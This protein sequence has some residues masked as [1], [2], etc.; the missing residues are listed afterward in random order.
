[1]TGPQDGKVPEMSQRAAGHPD[2]NPPANRNLLT[3]QLDS[4]ETIALT[5]LGSLADAAQLLS[6]LRSA[7]AAAALA[8]M[9]STLAAEVVQQMDPSMAASVLA[10]VRPDD[11]VDILERI[12]PARR[13]SLMQRLN[14]DDAAEVRQLENYPPDSAGGI[15]TTEVAAVVQDLT[16][17]AAIDK[18]RQ[19]SR[20]LD[21][22]Y[23][24]YVINN[25]GQLVGVL[26]MRE[27]LLADPERRVAE[28][29]RT[30]V[31]CVEHG[32]DQEE[33][34]RLLQRYG[35]LAVPVVDDGR[36]LIGL[37]TFDD[38]VDVLDEEA[39]EDIQKIGGS[40]ALDAPYLRIGLPTML[41]KRGG[42]LSALFLGEMLTA[43]AMGYFEDQ[44]ARAVVLVLFIPL[45]ISSGGNAGSQAATLIVRA[46]AV[47]E[48]RLRDWGRVLWRELCT[49]A[50]LGAWL[51]AI[52]FLRIV[53]WQYAGWTDYGSHPL[54]LGLSVWISLIG[55]VLIGTLAGSLLPLS[56]QWLGF[57]PATSSAPFVA[58][59]V[60]VSGLV[61]Y[62][63]VAMFVLGGT[64]L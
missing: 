24:V 20:D 58:T 7:D 8:Q 27:V 57:D 26:S 43:T 19:L 2:V 37:I 4:Y 29:M 17:A 32:M 54:L 18:V 51:G 53:L 62:F 35:F 25:G 10:D 11:R 30:N 28:V 44:I 49:G 6:R 23:Y 9:D 42:W 5:A 31:V 59:L 40:A 46:L 15:M 36:R 34:A 63:T 13:D 41:R 61:V 33:L 16:V 45:V 48:L 56:I 55:V 39:T 3:Q 47:G 12:D 21:Q 14:A 60:D 50:T 64:L 38:V 22:L 52:A 1:M